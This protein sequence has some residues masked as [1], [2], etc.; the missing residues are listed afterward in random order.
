MKNKRN[1]D[2]EEY[3]WK[4]VEFICL[5]RIKYFKIRLWKT[6]ERILKQI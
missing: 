2:G 5:K 6:T 4:K 3:E 1:D